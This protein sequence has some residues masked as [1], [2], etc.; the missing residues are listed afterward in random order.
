[1]PKADDVLLRKI[2]RCQSLLISS[3]VGVPCLRSRSLR[4]TRYLL[5]TAKVSGCVGKGHR[6]AIKLVAISTEKSFGSSTPHEVAISREV[7]MF[8]RCLQTAPAKNAR[9]G[10]AKRSA[11]IPLF[12]PLPC[13]TS[14]K[15]Q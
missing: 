12:D 6:H 10:D 4:R 14:Q 15:Q 8:G 3:H 11:P 2:F 9:Q 1:M 13:Y 5:S 7:F